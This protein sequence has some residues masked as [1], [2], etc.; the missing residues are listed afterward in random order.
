MQGL[1]PSTLRPQCPLLGH[2]QTFRTANVM[3]ALRPKAEMFAIRSAPRVSIT[4]RNPL[5]GGLEL[6]RTLDLG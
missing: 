3:S 1:K 4:D 6:F 5:L 2:K